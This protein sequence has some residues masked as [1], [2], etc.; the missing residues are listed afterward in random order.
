MRRPYALLFSVAFLLVPTLASACNEYTIIKY[1]VTQWWDGTVTVQYTGMDFYSD[2]TVTGG[3]GPDNGN[4]GGGG[5]GV[6]YIPIPP[7]I[8]IINVNTTD[9]YNPIVTADVAS[10]DPDDPVNEINLEVDGVT[11]DWA[12]WGIT[13]FARYQLH[14]PEI[15]YFP[16][17]TASLTAKACS[18]GGICSTYTAHIFRTTPSPNTANTSI[19]AAWIELDEG[20]ETGVSGPIPVTMHAYYGHGMRQMYTTTLFAVQR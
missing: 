20:G 3:G 16:D 5:P 8:S 15:I 7:S 18:A 2:C 19:Y 12:Y 13:P 14:L 9:P 1:Q 4:E 11:V 17:G 10:N 6:Y